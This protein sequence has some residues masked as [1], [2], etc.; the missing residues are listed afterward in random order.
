MKES[1]LFVRRI[2]STLL[3]LV[4]SLALVLFANGLFFS[5]AEAAFPFGDNFFFLA[6]L[7]VVL[8]TVIVL[9]SLPFNNRYALKPWLVTLVLISAVT[10]YYSNEF[11]VV[12]DDTMLINVLETN[13]SEAASLLT[14]KFL[15]YLALGGIL[16]S[17]IIVLWPVVHRSGLSS[18]WFNIKLATASVLIIVACLILF[19]SSYASFFRENKPI[20]YHSNPTYPIYSLIKLI[21]SGRSHWKPDTLKTVLPDAQ[22]SASDPH[23]ELMILVVGE[24]ARADHFSLYGYSRRTNPLLAEEPNLQVFADVSACGTSTAIS[25]PC[26]F[27]QRDRKDFDRSKARQE[28]DVLDILARVGI[29]VL[30]RD[31]NSSSKGVADRLPYEDFRSPKVN[32]VCNPECRDVGMLDGLQD[33]INRQPGDILIVLHQMGSHGPAY[34]KRVPEAFARFQPSCQSAQLNECSREE[35]INAY[36]NTILY[37]DYFLSE[38]IK[39]LKVNQMQFEAAMLYISDHGESLGEGGVYLHGIPYFMAPEAQTKVPTLLWYGPH[40]DIDEGELQNSLIHPTSHD[41]LFNM[42]VRL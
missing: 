32:P 18:V 4:I 25:V 22:I 20:R 1:K 39:L 26:M 13:P 28:E 24:T 12:I 6:S 41:F 15:A 7:G 16:P 36:D 11:G 19:G 3:I 33:Y 17:V 14:W 34:Y 38:V 30:W 27:S 10:A 9:L 29:S 35:I 40:N 31:N 2:T 8:C 23:R 42:L 5:K 21:T 37:T